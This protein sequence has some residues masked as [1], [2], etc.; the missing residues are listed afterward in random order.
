[1]PISPIL[2][3]ILPGPHGNIGLITLNRPE[4]LNALNQAMCLSMQAQLQQW[5]ELETVKAVVICGAGERAF[6]A[7]GDIRSIY[8]T[9]DQLDIGRH[10]FAREYH[11]NQTIYHFK[12]PYIA[13]MDGL[14]MGG[15]AGLSVNGNCRIGT[16][17]LQLAMPETGIGFFTDVGA[18]YFL[19]HAPHKLGWYLGL[20]GAVIGAADALQV[21]LIDKVMQHADFSALLTALTQAR[22]E[23]DPHQQVTQI[24]D[25][26]SPPALKKELTAYRPQIENC[27]AQSSLEKTL[28]A[29]DQKTTDTWSQQTAQHLRTRSPT[30]L[31]VVLEAL[32]RAALLDFDACMQME[33]RLAY[34]F[35]ETA[36]FYEGIRAAVIDKDCTPHWQ[37]AK[38][39]DVDKAMVKRYFDPLEC[40]RADLFS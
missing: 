12:K 35:L 29:L 33:Y 18:T 15:G 1:M 30:S 10:F 31:K 9:R 25:T 22:W 7:G 26:F 14:T 28:A 34:R 19:S 16:E 8:A 5:A 20:T 38:L 3:Q 11:L 27:F 40:S 4:Q 32:N 36:D 23:G 17:R 2:F 37:P 39:A 6:C 13:W 21:G 24:L